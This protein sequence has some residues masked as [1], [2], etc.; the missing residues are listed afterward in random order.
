MDDVLVAVTFALLALVVE[1]LAEAEV[2]A[3]P[4]LEGVV[5]RWASVH[6]GVIVHVIAAG[7]TLAGVVGLQAAAQ[8]LFMT[9]LVVPGAGTV[10]A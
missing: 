1:L 4:A 7:H 9:A 3:A 6:A 10:L 2:D 8:T 5:S